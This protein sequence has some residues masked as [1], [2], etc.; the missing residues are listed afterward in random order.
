MWSSS[1]EWSSVITLRLTALERDALHNP[2]T[3]IG[4]EIA[5]EIASVFQKLFLNTSA[6]TP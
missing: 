2:Q 3:E 1:S 5:I 6:L 4:I